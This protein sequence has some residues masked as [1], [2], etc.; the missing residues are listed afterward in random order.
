MSKNKTPIVELDGVSI[1]DNIACYK[2]ETF[3][4]PTLIEWCKQQD[5]PVFDT[6]LASLSIDSIPWTNLDD[7]YD[8][9]HHM[10]RVNDCSL[11]YPIMLAPNGCILDGAHRIC[12]A[13]ILGKKTIKCIRIQT[14][15]KCSGKCDT[16]KD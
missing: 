5:Y 6:P 16:T 12:K 7:M 11:E 9:C 13:I 10:K 14:M 1:V 2:G 3:D 15:P 8:F 4:V